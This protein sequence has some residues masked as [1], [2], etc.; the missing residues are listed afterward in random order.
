MT[1]FPEERIHYI[2]G[3]TVGIFICNLKPEARERVWENSDHF[4]MAKLTKMDTVANATGVN[5]ATICL[6][7]Q[8]GIFKFL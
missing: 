2:L 4:L 1:L 8:V 6:P 5:K 3:S 7:A